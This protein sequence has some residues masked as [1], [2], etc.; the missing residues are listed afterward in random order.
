MA[1]FSEQS[2]Y[3][4]GIVTKNRSGKSFLVL[5]RPLNL[6]RSDGDTF[7]TVTQEFQNRPDLISSTAYGIPDLWW[8]IYEYNGIRD[9]FFDLK[10]GTTILIPQLER[11]LQ[12]ITEIE[13]D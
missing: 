7:I 10:V 4:S 12:A 2:R 9:P 13:E 3:K 8:A 11:V 5:R 1:N 6:E